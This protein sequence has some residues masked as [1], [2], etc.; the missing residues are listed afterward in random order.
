MDE[1]GFWPVMS[2]PPRRCMSSSPGGTTLIDLMMLDVM[3]PERI[4]DLN[5]LAGEFRHI[6][7]DWSG[8]RLVPSHEWPTSRPMRGS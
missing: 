1:A 6:R 7:A 8:L 4:I 5:A 3:R 2:K